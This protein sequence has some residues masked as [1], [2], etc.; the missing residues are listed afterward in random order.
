MKTLKK[1]LSEKHM[2]FKRLFLKTFQL[3]ELQIFGS[4]FFH[5]IAAERKKEFRK[6][7]VLL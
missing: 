7:F 2:S 5:S 6:K 4:N 3:S 1:P